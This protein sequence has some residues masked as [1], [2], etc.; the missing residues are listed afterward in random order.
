MDC[1][2][3]LI[4]FM[5]GKINRIEELE[6]DLLDYGCKGAASHEKPLN[7]VYSKAVSVNLI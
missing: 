3:I 4:A 1:R 7:V 6:Y 2:E 5:R